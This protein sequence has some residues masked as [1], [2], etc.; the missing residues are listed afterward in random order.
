M[1]FPDFKASYCRAFTA[2]GYLESPAASIVEFVDALPE[3]RLQ[4]IAG[5]RAAKRAL[6]RVMITSEKRLHLH[7]DVAT[8]SLFATPPRASYERKDVVNLLRHFLGARIH[9]AIR[10]AHEIPLTD[11]AYARNLPHS[12]G[13]KR[14]TG[15]IEIEI[16]GADISITGGEIKRFSWF[17]GRQT[18]STELRTGRLTET[19]DEA[20]LTNQFAATNRAV[21][22]LIF[23]EGIAY[24]RD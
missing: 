3:K 14:Q 16:T 2:C 9:V 1:H 17:T 12:M 23:G 20:Y 21:K 22:R 6:V 8:R 15:G 10:A 24:A 5:Y 13:R 11:L 4:M 19:I 7:V 18:L